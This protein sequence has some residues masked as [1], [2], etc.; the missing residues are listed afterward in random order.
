MFKISPLKYVV[1][2][3]GSIFVTSALLTLYKFAAHPLDDIRVLGMVLGVAL[4]H[5]AVAGAVFWLSLGFSH[6]EPIGSQ[7][8]WFGVFC[9]CTSLNVM[10]LWGGIASLCLFVSLPALYGAMCAQA[11]KPSQ[12]QSGV[13]S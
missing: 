5:A 1:P 11:R 6:R 3:A 2:L 9:Y 8:A 7:T 10:S 12:P 4:L 13:K